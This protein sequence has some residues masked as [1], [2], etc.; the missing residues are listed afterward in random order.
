M[1]TGEAF[2]DPESDDCLYLFKFTSF[3][4]LIFNIQFVGEGAC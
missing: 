1:L 4:C 2:L 3:L